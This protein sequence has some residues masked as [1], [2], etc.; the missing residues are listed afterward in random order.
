M[1]K[2]ENVLIA[3]DFDGTLK[4]DKGEITQ[5]VREKIKY[6]ISNGGYFTVC[7]GRTYKGFHLYDSEY[8]NAPVLLVNGAMAYDY[9]KKRIVFSD[10]IGEEGIEAVRKILKEFP[11]IAVEMYPFDDTFAINPSDE[12]HRH[13]TSQGIEYKTV[14]DPAETVFPWAKAMIF[15]DDKTAEIQNFMRENVKEISFLPTRGSYIELLK[16]GANKGTGIYKLAEN[17]GVNRDDIYAV[18]DGYND[19]DMLLAAKAGFVPD[20]GSKEALE[21]ADYIVRSNNEGAVAEV[22]EILDKLY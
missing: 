12:S 8:I 18:G 10:G 3:S 22:I 21:V 4:N 13:F 2:F 20:N 15:A 11:G 17:L 6:F 9:E 5:D 19:V 1:K 16:C 7:T 14:S